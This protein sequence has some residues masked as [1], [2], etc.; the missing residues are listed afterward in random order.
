MGPA[1][2][3]DHEG[4]QEGRDHDPMGADDDDR[5]LGAPPDRMDRIWVHPTELSPVRTPTRARARMGKLVMP[6]A[7]GALGA[8][9]AITVLGVL[10]AFDGENDAPRAGPVDVQFGPRDE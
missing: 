9:V 7:A 1:G 2:D 10:G 3:E 4:H 5:P 6:L 8:I